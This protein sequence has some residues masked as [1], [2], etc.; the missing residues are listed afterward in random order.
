MLDFGVKKGMN[1]GLISNIDRMLLERHMNKKARRASGKN[2][3]KGPKKRNTEDDMH[4][5]ESF[6]KMIRKGM[7]NIY[8]T[9]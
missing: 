1:K 7:E 2:H 3:L 9:T 8:G 6:E 4:F 5:R